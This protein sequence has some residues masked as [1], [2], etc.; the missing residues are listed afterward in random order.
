ME[1]YK[2]AQIFFRSIW[3]S[4]IQKHIKTEEPFK[5]IDFK[6]KSKI[7]IPIVIKPPLSYKGPVPINPNKKEN[8]LELLPYVNKN[9]HLFYEN[10]ITKDDIPD[11]LS[12]SDEESE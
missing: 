8:L 3:D 10:L 2:V 4:A 6:R 11:I 12:S 7:S 9:F 5:K 1:R